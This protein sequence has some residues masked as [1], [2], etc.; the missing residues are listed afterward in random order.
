MDLT[1]FFK[2]R[3]VIPLFALPV[4]VW[5][6]AS[7]PE[8]KAAPPPDVDEKTNLALRRAADA[9]LRE[10]G[11]TLSRIPAVER[12]GGGAWRVF[13]EK[14]FRYES[15]PARLQESLDLYGI[16]QPYRVAVRRCADF[17]IDLGFHQADVLDGKRLPCAGRDEP[18]GCHFIEVTFEG[19][20]PKP[21]FPISK[22]AI[23][24]LLFGAA[25]AGFWFFN[26]K[27][28]PVPPLLPVDFDEKNWLSVGQSKLNAAAQVLVCG[29]SHI[30][31]TFQEAK[32]LRLFAERPGQLLERQQ[33]LHEVWESEG[34]LVG[35]RSVD[36]CVSRL[37]KKLAGD[38][39]VAIVAVHGMGYRLEARGT[40]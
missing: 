9:L 29:G 22:A 10:S 23:V 1:T 19:V 39:S 15:L 30:E 12:G 2:K 6:M 5:A 14:P 38:P 32:L 7:M 20:E 27:T 26:K 34:V 13:L 36:M 28:P 3:W 35:G 21:A 37:R 11:D 8:R 31:L 40:A 18:G 16:R 17:T 24:G 25:A 33:I 4:L